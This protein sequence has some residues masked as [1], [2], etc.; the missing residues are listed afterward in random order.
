MNLFQKSPK[1]WLSPKLSYDPFGL[2]PDTPASRILDNFNLQKHCVALGI[3]QL[4]AMQF[5]KL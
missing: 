3:L 4:N 2:N 1:S 5:N